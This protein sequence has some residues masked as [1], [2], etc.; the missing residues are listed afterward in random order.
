MVVHEVVD[1]RVVVSEEGRDIPDVDP[2][3]FQALET[4]EVVC[5]AVDCRW[6]VL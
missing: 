1:S 6:D 2:P 3:I 5:K 4:R